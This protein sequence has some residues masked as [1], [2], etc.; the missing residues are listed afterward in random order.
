MKK[1]FTL[2]TCI[3]SLI[4]SAAAGLGMF[5]LLLLTSCYYDTNPTRHP[6]AFPTSIFTGIFAL[7]IF[8][9]CF[10]KYVQARTVAPSLLGTIADVLGAIL[11]SPVFG[12][13][14]ALLAEVA[15]EVLKPLWG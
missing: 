8:I 10:Y 1:H 5:S 3:L 2:K 7:L 11:L 15:R 4:L 14:F 6:I 9:L 13:L 12:Y